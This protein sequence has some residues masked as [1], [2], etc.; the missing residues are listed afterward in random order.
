MDRLRIALE[1][2]GVH[3]E[4]EY[5]LS[6]HSTFRIGGR[7]ALAVFPKTEEQMIFTLQT[8]CARS[9]AFHLIGKASNVLF[10]D[11]NF[12]GAIIFTHGFQSC[13]IE[14]NRIF[15]DAGASL[16]SIAV[17]AKKAELTGFEFAHGIPGTLGGALVMNAG[18]YGGCIGDVCVSSKCFDMESGDVR[19]FSATEHEFAYRNSIYAR[20]SNYAILGATLELT[21]G[22][23]EEIQARMEDFKQRR[24]ASQPLEYP[25]AGSVFKRPVGHFAGKLIEDCGLKG[26]REGGAQV[27]T[28]HAGFIVNLGGAT[29]RDVRALIEKIQETVFRETG[30][31]LESE[32]RFL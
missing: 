5:C 1:N 15:A 28:K 14:N 23:E 32:I 8:V 30:V 12:D 29:A 19:T 22:A 25:S 16:F 31:M 4:R 17:A 26:V 13:R 24:R 18:A 2:F 7:C 21:P 6:E 20:H 9:V 27:S 3:T 10:S 11:E